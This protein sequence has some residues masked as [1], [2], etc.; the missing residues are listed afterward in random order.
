MIKTR[1][2]L[3]FHLFLKSR[4]W[5]IF[6]F[7]ALL[8]GVRW[9][10]GAGFLDF[11]AVL[12]KPLLPGTA[13]REWIQEGEN[14]ERNIRLRLLEEDNHRLRKALSLQQLNGDQRISAAVISRSSRNWWQLLEINKGA[15]D[16]VLKGQTVI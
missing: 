3:G 1:R 14:I 10:K 11:Y 9:T 16:G 12:L 15:K 2:K 8:L 6:L 4:F 7:A 5:V 13:Q